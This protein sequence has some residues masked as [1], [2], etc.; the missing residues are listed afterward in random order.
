MSCWLLETSAYVAG[1]S[2]IGAAQQGLGYLNCVLNL[3]AGARRRSD[4]VRFSFYGLADCCEGI[5]VSRAN[6]LIFAIVILEKINFC[7]GI[8]LRIS[9]MASATGNPVESWSMRVS[10]RS[11]DQIQIAYVSL[12]AYG[13]FLYFP[14][15][16]YAF[17]KEHFA[18]R[19]CFNRQFGLLARTKRPHRVLQT[20]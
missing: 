16:E 11:P 12:H 9:A 17:S 7:M 4:P 10:R 15:D 6:H 2:G 20:R 18:P 5:F 13:P 3:C 19:F 8:T 14:A 1:A